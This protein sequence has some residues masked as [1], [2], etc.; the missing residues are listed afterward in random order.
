[1]NTALRIVAPIVLLLIAAP[2]AEPPPAAPSVAKQNVTVFGEP[3]RYGGWPA[4]HGLW[5]W[6]DEL[7]AGFE[8]AW[9]KPAT[10][11]HAVDRSKPF[12]NWQARSLDGGRTWKTESALPFREIGREQPPAPLIEPLDFAAPDFA[13]MF[14][15]GSIQ[16]GPSWFYASGDRCRTWRGP[17]AFSVEGIDKIATRTDLVALGPRDCL[18]FG[19]AAKNNDKEGR[20]FC[21]RTTDGGMHWKLVSWIGPEPEEFA[22]MPSTVRLAGGALLTAIRNGK[23]GFNITVWRSDDFGANWRPLGAATPDIGGNPPALVQL[24]DGRLCLSYGCRRKPFGVRA[25][26]SGD[27]GRTWGPE[28]VLRDDGLTGDLGYPRSVVRPDGKVLTVYYFNGPHDEDRTIQATIWAPPPV[29]AAMPGLDG[30]V[31]VDRVRF[32]PAPDREPAMAGGRFSGSNLSPRD[33]FRVLAEIKAEPPHGEWSELRFENSTPYR[34]VRYEAPAGSRGNVAEL[35]FHAGA[36]KLH[37][38]GF[39]SPGS[40]APGGH[41]KTVFDGKTETWFNSNNPDGQFVGL[42]LEDQA[43]A[44]RP[45]ITPNGGDWE[46]PQLV[47]MRSRT[48]GAAIRYTLD[49]TT[50]GPK[51]GRP[52]AGA[53]KVATNTTLV[54]VSFKEGLAASPASVATIWIGKPARPPLHSFHVGNS[55]TGN[56]SRFATFVRTAGGADSFP[57]Y[58]IGGATTMRLWNDAT[59][60]NEAR[61]V[62]TY[63]KAVHPLDCF[64]LQPRDFNVAEEADYAARF[65]RLVRGKS[66]EVQPWLYAEWVELP[67]ARPTD[68]GEV[69]SRQMKKTFPALTWEES[70]GAMLLYNEEVRSEIAARAPGGKPVRNSP[71]RRRA[72]QVSTRRFSRITSM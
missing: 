71:A 70:M 21:A 31:V 1:M 33:G 24:K 23:P 29:Q 6:G 44:A 61:W 5:Q 9:Y 59:G 12:E 67:R 64:T 56:A 32:F 52:Y 48:P 16:V 37:G 7:V 14:R 8:V 45:L 68:R 11:D 30:P 42:D 15:F 60:T 39:G 2:A 4:N 41:W 63:A 19:S 46:K 50:P 47:T 55:L 69:P 18:M 43:S 10:N 20:T 22:I 36:H 28:L 35:E 65:I 66:P 38:A 27:E 72:R 49:G 13:L 25:H 58:L 53:F 3:G 26:L 51:D 62:E 54:A 40:L 17:F 57:A 34:W